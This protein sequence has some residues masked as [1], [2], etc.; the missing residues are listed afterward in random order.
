[1]DHVEV[2]DRVVVQPDGIGASRVLG[3]AI[4]AESG[5][6]P[7]ELQR[8]L[9]SRG[10]GRVLRDSLED[11]DAGVV[12]LAPG[13]HFCQCVSLDLRNAATYVGSCQMRWR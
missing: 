4:V 10:N 1:M 12:T 7:V 2:P 9:G 5:A 11:V 3:Q 13:F 6:G 8:D